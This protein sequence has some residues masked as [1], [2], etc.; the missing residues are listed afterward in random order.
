MGGYIPAPE[1][2]R[3]AMLGALDIASEEELFACVPES[4]RLNRPLN[5]PSGKSEMETLE[6]MRRLTERNTVFRSVFRGAGAY[7]HYI[8]AAV[9][10][11]AAREEFVTAY[12]PYQPEVSQGTLQSIFEF[13][14]MICELTGMDAANASVYDGAVAAAEAAAMCK[15]PGRRA[16]VV[17]AAA[18]PHV[19]SIR[20]LMAA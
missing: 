10:R 1:A 19:M 11:A 6:A 7:R 20:C 2:S 4:V 9:K 15:E 17:S 16:V 12:T 13:Q 18:H 5:L 3:R 8:P 14:T